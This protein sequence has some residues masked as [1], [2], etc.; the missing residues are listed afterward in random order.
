[1][2]SPTFGTIV[3]GLSEKSLAVIRAFEAPLDASTEANI[4]LTLRGRNG[5]TALLLHGEVWVWVWIL[6]WEERGD[7]WEKEYK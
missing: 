2:L 7:K 3:G 4:V 5:E 6:T 1:M